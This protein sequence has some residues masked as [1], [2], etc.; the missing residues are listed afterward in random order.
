MNDGNSSRNRCTGNFPTVFAV[1]ERC[2][3]K[4]GWRRRPCDVSLIKAVLFYFIPGTS[5]LF[6]F[7]GVVHSFGHF[8][9]LVSYSSEC[10]WPFSKVPVQFFLLPPQAVMLFQFPILRFLSLL[11]SRLPSSRVSAL[12]SQ[13]N[14]LWLC[15]CPRVWLRPSWLP[16]WEPNRSESNGKLC[17]DWRNNPFFFI[18]TLVFPADGSWFH[19]ITLSGNKSHTPSSSMCRGVFRPSA[20][21]PHIN[22]F[23][24]RPELI[25]TQTSHLSPSQSSVCVLWIESSCQGKICSLT[26]CLCH[27][28]YLYLRRTNT[29]LMMIY[30]SMHQQ[31][32]RLI[33]LCVTI[34]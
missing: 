30:G 34:S 13:C 16:E 7:T 6:H 22:K 12:I 21:G 23:C 18:I 33:W 31:L 26:V 28:L 17:E 15:F 19:V 10:S 2:V 9:F 25:L 1:R 29:W 4:T 8:C 24:R 14:M 5:S 32:N 3:H 20:S 27:T 11:L